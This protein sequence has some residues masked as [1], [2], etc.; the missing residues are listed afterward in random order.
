MFKV[1]LDHSRLHDWS[2]HERGFLALLRA[3]RARVEVGFHRLPLLGW[4]GGV[5][6]LLLCTFNDHDDGRF[7]GLLRAL[8][9]EGD[10]LSAA[11]SHLHWPRLCSH[12]FDLLLDD[13]IATPLAVLHNEEAFGQDFLVLLLEP[14]HKLIPI[15]SKLN[16]RCSD[17]LP[18]LV[19]YLHG[20]I[21]SLF[22]FR[23]LLPEGA[24]ALRGLSDRLI[25]L[26]RAH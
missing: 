15:L 17:F 3:D 16:F 1:R 4:H 22:F 2:S 24:S 23:H 21:E 5:L 8:L 20:L 10:G 18:L 25:L 26:L 12:L 7:L 13:N 14:N 11:L 9:V 19:L 6:T